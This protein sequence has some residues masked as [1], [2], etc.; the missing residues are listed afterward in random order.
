MTQLGASPWQTNHDGD[1]RRVGIEIELNGIAFPH[2]VDT[3]AKHLKLER[4]D[5]SRYRS[6]LNGAEE[7]DW[8]IELDFDLLQ[9]MASDKR[10][11]SALSDNIEQLLGHI[12]APLVPLE[13]VSPPL[14]LSKLQDVENLI[15]T[16]REEG[17][18][19]T[20]G[21]MWYAFGLQLN[22]EIHSQE[23]EH[24]L[25]QLKAFLLLYDWL[26][27]ESAVNLTRKLTFF[28]DPFPERYLKQ[29]LRS[30]YWPTSNRSWAEDYL[31]DNPTRNRA[32]DLL[33][34]LAWLDE[35]QV[36][37][38]TQD[39]LIKKRPA[40]HYRLPNCEIHIPDWGLANPWNR[41]LQV[42]YLAADRQRLDACC[43]AWQEFHN[44]PFWSHWGLR[45]SWADRV[46]RQWL[47]PI[48]KD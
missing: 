22:P 14:P 19:G 29:V 9:K 10:N 30:N 42:E 38:H 39:P 5:E 24:L 33:P 31:Q 11:K 40:L 48:K 37:Q 16:L 6:K 26:A 35:E 25:A 21:S 27:E 1:E 8:V 36:A 17:A 7:G 32:L 34:L 47:V 4:V 45:K 15:Q 13:I 2:L 43:D 46:R 18:Q 3:V 41:W 23:P 12:S 20:S 28:V 44:R